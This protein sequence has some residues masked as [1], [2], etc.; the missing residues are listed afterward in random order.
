MALVIADRVRE[1]TA[2]SGTGTITLAGAFAGFQPF[3]VIGNGNTTYYCII[4]AA[5][6]AWEVGIGTYTSSGNTLSRDTVLSS[7][8]SDALVPF[9]AG[10]K[11]VICTQPA[12]RAVLLDSATNATIPGITLSGG[13]A[14]GV[15]YLNGSKVLTT[16]TALTFDGATLGSIRSTAGIST[17]FGSAAVKTDFSVTH[18]GTGEAIWNAYP[19]S[20]PSIASAMA[21]QLGGSEQMRLTSTGL[22]IGTTTPFSKL[23]GIGNIGFYRSTSTSAG[24]PLGAQIYL[25]DGGFTNSA[26]Y[27]SAPG[28]GAVFSTVSNVADSLAFYTYTGSMNSRTEQVRITAPGNLLVGYTADQGSGKL[29][30]NGAGRIGAFDFNTDDITYVGGGNFQIGTVFG[31]PMLFKTSNAERMRIT[32]AGNVGIGT[33]SPDSRLTVSAAGDTTIKIAPSSAGTARLNL[34]GIG[35]GAA[36]ITSAENGLYLANTDA[37]PF[38]FSINST[39]RMRLDSA[40]NLG[41]SIVP[42]TWFSNRSVLQIGN[43]VGVVAASG[44]NFDQYTNGYIDAS[45]VERYY[46]AGAANKFSA[47]SGSFKWFTAASGTA[48]AAIAFTQA[49]TLNASGNLGIGTTAPTLSLNIG[50]STL[51]AGIATTGA[52]ISTDSTVGA[53]LSIRRSASTGN[54]T[55]AQFTSSGTASAPTAV[56][57]NR[58]LGRNDWY[59]FDGTNYINAAAILAAVDGT[60]GTNSMPGRI[61]FQTTASGSGSPTE[62]MRIDS[63]GNVGIGTSSPNASAILDAQSTTKGVRMPNMTTTQKNAIAS[64][65]AGLMV[66]DTTLAKLCVYT[67]AAWE[68]I[69]SI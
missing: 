27:N 49:M 28:M 16:G 29:Q 38:V 31:L 69:T 6:G 1:T 30:V 64:P 55:F 45:T 66:F 67:G 23:T 26:Y 43:S 20:N 63:S 17:S 19:T 62:R 4:D 14:N 34:N 21:W 65:A 37:A 11:D 42:S 54:A 15:A 40:G 35:G 9:A 46:Q 56:V 53:L 39:E 8:N 10:T 24:D 47:D 61:I 50:D 59:G 44:L 60:P 41:L 18:I 22:G 58:G 3:S 32:S 52:M 68:T 51:P 36:A 13:T 48:N 33:S 12:E 5:T 57:N 7:S 2:S 25:G